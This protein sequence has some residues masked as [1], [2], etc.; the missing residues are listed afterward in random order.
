MNSIFVFYAGIVVL[1]VVLGDF[2]LATLGASPRFVISDQ[3]VRLLYRPLVWLCRIKGFRWLSPIVGVLVMVGVA[4][5]WIFG[6]AWGWTLVFLSDTDSIKLN[7]TA[8]GSSPG[9][10]DYHAHVGHLLS[11]LGATLTA[12]NG[13]DWNL[14]GA[15]V[16]T[17]GMILLT[18]SFSFIL[19]TTQTVQSGRAL[20][21]LV[22]TMPADGSVS[23]LLPR[24]A[25]V[26]AAL[27]NAP[28]AAYYCHHH[29]RRDLGVAVLRLAVRARREGGEVEKRALL[30]LSDLPHIG[31]SGPGDTV[32]LE[33]VENWAR[34]HSALDPRLEGGEVRLR[35]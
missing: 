16:G 31:C 34:R 9:F 22:R 7:S 19:S 17:N 11:T 29:E 35:A 2:L 18:L 25:D 6:T 10:W 1:V 21:S 30:L 24:L 33:D 32:T 15:A 5:F 26:V 20:A 23:D 28:F 27:N 3:L 4:T 8:P 12:P 14:V 13:T